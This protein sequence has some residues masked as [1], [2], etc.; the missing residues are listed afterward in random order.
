M[1]FEVDAL[2]KEQ[3]KTPVGWLSSNGLLDDSL[4]A[5]HL[6]LLTEEDVELLSSS[7]VSAAHCPGSNAKAAKG[8]APVLKMMDKGINVTLAT[9]G[10]ASGNTLELYTTLRLCAIL[11]KNLSHD[12]SVAPAKRIVP[13]AT[14]NAGIALKK[15][16]G[17][18]RK[19][20]ESDVLVLSRR[21][22]N[23]I[24]SYD[25]YSVLVYSAGVQNVKD[26]YIA[27]VRKVHDG[28]LADINLDELEAEFSSVSAPFHGEAL[29]LSQN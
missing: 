11:Q 12:R 3:G 9:D 13:L 7:G 6:L 21:R 14:R 27:G 26:L 16:I 8:V 15:K 5:A 19:G 20:W 23:M 28:M 18:L 17:V 1:A 24:P 2:R 4:L 22:P 29:K 25:P 10:P